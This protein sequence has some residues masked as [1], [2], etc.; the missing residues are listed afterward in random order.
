LKINID[1]VRKNKKL[2]LKKKENE[3]ENNRANFQ[4]TINIINRLEEY[5]KQELDERKKNI[6]NMLE[7]INFMS[8]ISIYQQ[9]L[10]GKFTGSVIPKD[11]I[12]ALKN[13]Q[14]IIINTFEIENKFIDYENKHPKDNPFD[15]LTN[16]QMLTIKSWLDDVSNKK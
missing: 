4:Q 6:L 3:K 12:S 15:K 9:L 16:E 8:I 5:Q 7:E 2:E 13:V 10:C 11:D 14:D 1:E